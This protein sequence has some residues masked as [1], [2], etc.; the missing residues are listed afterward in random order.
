[1]AKAP[2]RGSTNDHS[3]SERKISSNKH[4]VKPWTM[5]GHKMNHKKK[6]MRKKNRKKKKRL[7]QDQSGVTVTVKS[8]PT[9][10]ALLN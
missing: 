10:K 5:I 3:R 8:V 9:I 6:M 2:K 7:L 4:T 1:M